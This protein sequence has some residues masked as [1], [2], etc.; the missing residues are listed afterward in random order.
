MG[1]TIRHCNHSCAAGRWRSMRALLLAALAT[2]PFAAVLVAC[3]GSES[4]STVATETATVAVSPSAVTTP[5]PIKT[6]DV[7]VTPTPVPTAPATSTPEAGHDAIA[8]YPVYDRSTRTGNPAADRVIAAVIDGDLDSAAALLQSLRLPCVGIEKSGA[9]GVVRCDAS[10]ADGT[11]ISVFP[12]VFADRTY[13]RAEDASAALRQMVRAGARV[14]AVYRVPAAEQ[15][16]A[17]WPGGSL[18][19]VF[20]VD[21]R[22]LLARV[23]DG[24]IVLLNLGADATRSPYDLTNPYG[25]FLLPPR[26]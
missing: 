26:K 10:E 22:G 21:G 8:I 6:E 20:V 13:L 16:N 3:G 15:G 19:I 14:F 18:G 23:N 1:T 24:G 7:T 2:V 25:D 12:V 17:D 11:I 9:S 4:V 5:P